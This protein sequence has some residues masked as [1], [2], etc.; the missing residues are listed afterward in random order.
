MSRIT[1]TLDKHLN[2]ALRARAA[3][4]G[5]RSRSSVARAALAA[6]LAALKTKDLKIQDGKIQDGKIQDTRPEPP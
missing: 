3:A 5:G 6:W 2:A 4:D 1:I